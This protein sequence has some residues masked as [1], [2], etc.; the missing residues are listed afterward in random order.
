M[1]MMTTPPKFSYTPMGVR[2]DH[3][4]HREGKHPGQY[5]LHCPN[6]YSDSRVTIFFIMRWTWVRF[7]NH[8]RLLTDPATM[9]RRYYNKNHRGDVFESLESRHKALLAEVECMNLDAWST[10][11]IEPFPFPCPVPRYPNHQH[12]FLPERISLINLG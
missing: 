7:K 10:G 9:A 2:K 4:V 3:N 8:A 6:Y 1:E 12:I 11:R 5:D